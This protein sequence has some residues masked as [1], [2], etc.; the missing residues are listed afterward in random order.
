MS[1][2]PRVSVI[3]VNWNGAHHLRICLPSLVEQTYRSMEI[4]VVD[5]HSTD[6]SLN[7]TQEFQA[8]WLPLQKNVGLAP[9]L[10]RGA[11]AAH[12]EFLLFVNNDMRFD[13]GFVAALVTHLEENETIFATDGLQ[14][15]WDGNAKGHMA[16]RLTK[17]RGKPGS[18]EIVPGLYFFQEDE[19]QKASGLMASAACMLV[20]ATL[21]QK[22]GGFDDR[23][24]LGYED[25]EICW[26]ARLRGWEIIYVPSAVCWHRVG[27]SG[28][29]MEGK[30]LSFRGV[31][32]GRLLLATKL[33]PM[34]Y[35]FWTWLISIAALSKDLMKLRFQLAKDRLAIL[36]EMAALVPEVLRERKLLFE[37]AG[38]S[39]KQHLES[40]LKLNSESNG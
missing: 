19:C 4:I 39:P 9:A 30:R 13:R 34:R 7:V 29:S 31:L 16:V 1:A 6:E 33:L 5:N 32:T 26:R 3:I 17:R 2:N 35:A 22:L 15:S 8:R 28:G 36:L 37:T 11:A 10:N 25:L 23:L 24:P 40:L 18:V 12:G 27:S 21:F 20:R 14:F 38:S